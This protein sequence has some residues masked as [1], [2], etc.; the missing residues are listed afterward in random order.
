MLLSSIH[1][2]QQV[3]ATLRLLFMH[4]NVKPV[5]CKRQ[6][7][8]QPSHHSMVFICTCPDGLLRKT[9]Y[10]PLHGAHTFKSAKDFRKRK[11]LTIRW[12]SYPSIATCIFMRPAHCVKT[13][14]MWHSPKACCSKSMKKVRKPNARNT[15]QSRWWHLMASSRN[16]IR[17]QMYGRVVYHIDPSH[18]ATNFG[19]LWMQVIL[20]RKTGRLSLTCNVK[21]K[22]WKYAALQTLFLVDLWILIKSGS[23]DW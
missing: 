14:L 15:F 10:T 19:I 1:L 2:V 23:R 6:A 11:R 17:K 16:A 20:N 3:L 12:C 4:A 13:A 21:R 18:P 8:K 5:R 9:S 22:R 7:W